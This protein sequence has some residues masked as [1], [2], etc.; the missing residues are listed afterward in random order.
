MLWQPVIE[1]WFKELSPQQWWI[2]DNALD[3]MIKTR[4]EATLNKAKEYGLADWRYQ[5]RGRLAEIIV[6]DQFSR[7]IYRDSPEAFAVDDR[8]V[9]LT[10]A[11]IESGDDR[12]LTQQERLFV[13]MPLMHSENPEMHVIAIEVFSALG[14]EENLE[15]ERKHKAII[16][17]FGR[18]PHRNAI[19]GRESTPEELEFLKQPDSS[20]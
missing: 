18:Y 8:A 9:Q 7:N 14:L 11:A 12:S 6:L 13:Y 4:F 10:L 19:L 16:D 15:F 20:F 1:F 5:P 17:R 3:Q 2:K